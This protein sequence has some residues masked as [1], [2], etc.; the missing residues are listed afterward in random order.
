[1]IFMYG[2][3]KFVNDYIINNCFGGHH[4]SPWEIEIIVS[5]TRTPSSG[6]A[7]YANL[8]IR[9]PTFFREIF[10][11]FGQVDASLFSVPIGKCENFC[12]IILDFS[13]ETEK[14][15][16]VYDWFFL[17]VIVFERME[18]PKIMENIVFFFFLLL[19]GSKMFLY[20]IGFLVYEGIDNIFWNRK[21][22]ADNES[23]RSGNLNRNRTSRRT[24]D[25]KM[26]Y[27]LHYLKKKKDM[28]VS[29]GFSLVNQGKLLTFPANLILF[30]IFFTTFFSFMNKKTTSDKSSLTAG[31]KAPVNSEEIFKI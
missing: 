8:T 27:F 29:Y 15:F 6:G 11:S 10:N 3:C 26:R 24:D 5:A 21:R 20:P 18:Y 1:M 25:F 9:K 16:R 14:P 23:F 22:S 31:N 28:F 17:C 4:K 30:R 2:M 12:F 19:M 7:I 13:R